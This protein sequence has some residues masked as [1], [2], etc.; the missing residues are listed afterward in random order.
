[1]GAFTCRYTETYPGSACESPR[2]YTSRRHSWPPTSRYS[3]HICRAR[4]V[5]KSGRRHV[6]VA[7]CA[8]RGTTSSAEAE[9]TASPPRPGPSPAEGEPPSARR[10]RLV[11]TRP[12]GARLRILGRVGRDAGGAARADLLSTSHVLDVNLPCVCRLQVG[13][14]EITTRGSLGASARYMWFPVEG[15]AA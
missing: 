14:I 11:A 3:L 13:S 1:M 4:D 6:H 2:G 9:E 5:A 8:E 15:S 7:E 10:L 12:T